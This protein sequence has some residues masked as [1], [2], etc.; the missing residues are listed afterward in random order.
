MR[1]LVLACAVAI[2]ATTACWKLYTW[3]PNT[4]G[5]PKPSASQSVCVCVCGIAGSPEQT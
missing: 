5:Y 3:S 2:G 4:N 1:N